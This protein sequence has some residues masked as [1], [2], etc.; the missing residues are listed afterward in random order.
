M[1]GEYGNDVRGVWESVMRSFLV[2]MPSSLQVVLRHSLWD[3]SSLRYV[4]QFALR[5]W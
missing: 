3:T 2:K 5:R 1:S 4:L